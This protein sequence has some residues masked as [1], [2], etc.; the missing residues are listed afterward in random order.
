MTIQISIIHFKIILKIS[1]SKV[2]ST[3]EAAFGQGFQKQT[4]PSFSLMGLPVWA[5]F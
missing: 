3:I 4:Y 1:P 2:T 5:M